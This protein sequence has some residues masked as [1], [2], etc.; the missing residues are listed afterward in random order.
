[1]KK[2]II[3]VL[4]CL[5]LGCASISEQAKM[6]AYDRTMDAYQTVMRLSNFNDVCKYVDP[7]EMGRKDCLKQYANV[8]IVSYDVLGVNVAEDKLEVTQ[9]VEVEYFFVDRY[10]V[11][12]IEYEQSW[13]YM[14]EME[15]W[16]LQT[17]PP[18]FE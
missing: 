1:M 16:L 5:P 13:R 7:S 18:H 3:A 6:E 17:G 4:I 2:M 10:V 11:E 15:S 14:K 12:K 9:T 8:K